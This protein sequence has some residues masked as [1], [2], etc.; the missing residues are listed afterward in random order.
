MPEYAN[1]EHNFTYGPSTC[2]TILAVKEPFSKAGRIEYD[3]RAGIMAPHHDLLKQLPN[4]RLFR[5]GEHFFR[6][7]VHHEPL[8]LSADK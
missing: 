7:P 4:G 6:M 2:I 8:V 1:I 3:R 5:D